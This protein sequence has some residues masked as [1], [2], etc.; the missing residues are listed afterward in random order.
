MRALPLILLLALASSCD[1]DRENDAG[2]AGPSD[3]APDAFDDADMEVESDAEPDADADV[4]VD[5]GCEA[6]TGEPDL[7]DFGGDRRIELEATGFFRVDQIC[8][9]WWLVT[10]DGHPFYSVGVNHITSAG[11][12]DQETGERIYEQTVSSVYESEDD[13]A[14]T[15][16]ERLR[17]WGFNTAG[18]WSN[19]GLMLPRMPFCQILG[20][21]HASWLTGELADYFDPAWE[22]E[23]RAGA[24]EA[25]ELADEPN[26]V[27]YFLDN[28]LHW[29]PDW[30]RMETLLQLY[31]S[32]GPDAPGKVAAVDLLLDELEGIE[33]VNELLGSDFTGREDFLEATE[34]W[35]RLTQGSSET[36][37]RLTSRFLRL[38]AERYFSV[39]TSA[40][41]ENDPNHL[42]LGNREVSVMTR[43][44]VYQ[45]AAPYVDVISINNYTF[46]DIVVESAL[47]MSGGLDPS[48]GFAALHEEMDVPIMITEFGFRAAG[49]GL[50][51]SYPPIYPI[52]GDQTARTEAFT[53]YAR[54]HQRVPWIVGYHWF[55]WVDQPVGGRFD[56]EDNN[57]GL[58]SELD[59]PYMVLT[60]RMSEV[61]G[62]I[63]SY[64]RRPTEE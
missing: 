11:D 23:V 51:N 2:D 54:L 34:G 7:D 49:A 21:A 6:L 8:D 4:E 31:L 38:A 22:A 63:W 18:S 25:A 13:W 28:E 33:G 42:I 36:E 62:E 5:D 58:V 46:P 47:F 39:T 1:D 24:E 61:N 37:A 50:P 14:D 15:T 44:E 41:R 48:E 16:V 20:L 9:R 27:G 55:E 29:G 30:R 64:L 10:P 57:W 45:A 19:R 60:E 12:E 40:I 53:E 56:G 59:E 35:T 17:A 52:Y 3:A 32:F 26:L 43:L